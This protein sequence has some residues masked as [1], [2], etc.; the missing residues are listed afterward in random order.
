MGPPRIA[1]RI[2]WPDEDCQI[3]RG[4]QWARAGGRAASLELQGRLREDDG[5][6]GD[7]RGLVACPMCGEQISVSASF[8][9]AQW[10]RGQPL[11]G[12][13]GCADQMLYR[14]K[15]LGRNRVEWED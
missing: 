15:Q 11:S 9:V 3:H 10:H 13:V 7:E 4:V 8:G 1:S 5:R 14:A 6:A 2:A 12:L